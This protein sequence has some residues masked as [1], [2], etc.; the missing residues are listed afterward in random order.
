MTPE[1]G[2]ASSP[3]DSAIVDLHDDE[4]TEAGN[5]EGLE[6]DAR[7]ATGIVLSVSLALWLARSGALLMSL[8]LSS[9]AWRSYD[10]LPVVRN[11]RDEDEEEEEGDMDAAHEG[12]VESAT[13]IE[14]VLREAGG[15][16]E[17]DDD[18][19]DDGDRGSEAHDD[20][21]R[22]DPIEDEPADGAGE[23][24]HHRAAFFAGER[25]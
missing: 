14:D 24:R 22:R 7:L 21:D 13:R 3:P 10:L 15:R 11:Q 12:G 1:S 16:V 5:G 17:D 2:S 6:V 23:G 25:G 4:R 9:P 19:R 20:D 18:G 8:L